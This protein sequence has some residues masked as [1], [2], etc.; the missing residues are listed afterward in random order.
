MVG[1]WQL[2]WSELHCWELFYLFFFYMKKVRFF[3]THQLNTIKPLK[4][5]Q[6]IDEV[7]WF[8]L[9]LYAYVQK[10]ARNRFNSF[11]HEKMYFLS[12]YS[13]RI[14]SSSF[15]NDAKLELQDLSYCLEKTAGKSCLQLFFKKWNSGI[16]KLKNF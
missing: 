16:S 6:K 4:E 13:S 8:Q 15:G 10:T 9:F 14:I 5:W 2:T 7:Q 1:N 11:C 3:N 12:P